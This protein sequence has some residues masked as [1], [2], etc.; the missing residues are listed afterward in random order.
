MMWW[1]WWVVGDHGGKDDVRKR[2]IAGGVTGGLV[3]TRRECMVS[4]N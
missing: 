3:V 2:W 1:Q 4:K